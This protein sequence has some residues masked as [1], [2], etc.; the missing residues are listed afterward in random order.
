MLKPAASELRL[1]LWGLGLEKDG[2]VDLADLPEG[3]GQGLTS[4]V[5]DRTTPRG[6]YGVC[7]YRIC[8]NRVV[9]IDMLER[10]ADIIRD[11]VFWRPRI[12]EEKRPA[13]SVEGGGFTI[14]PDM[15]SLVG[16]SGEDFQAILRSLDFRMHRKKVKLPKTE[17]ARSG[18]RT[19]PA[20]GARRLLLRRNCAGP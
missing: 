4:A 1:I 16:C 11:R 3:P 20:R 13:G 10:L 14:V 2:R 6:F 12:P 17:P 8:G 9:R 5:F 15:M 18:F 7:G 19:F